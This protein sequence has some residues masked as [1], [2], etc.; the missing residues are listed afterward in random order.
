MMG[1]G[2]FEID[3][4]DARFFRTAGWVRLCERRVGELRVRQEAWTADIAALLRGQAGAGFSVMIRI[5]RSAAA[6]QQAA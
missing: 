5:D 6:A 2:F 1:D 4:S 3:P